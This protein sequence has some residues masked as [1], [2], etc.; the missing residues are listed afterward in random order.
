MLSYLYIM[1][2]ELNPIIVDY[3]N[4][5]HLKITILMYFK[6]GRKNKRFT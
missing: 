3:N 1:E 5:K 2:S 4:D 6:K